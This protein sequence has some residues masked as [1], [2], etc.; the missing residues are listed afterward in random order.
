[1]PDAPRVTKTMEIK[2]L[3]ERAR[4]AF[5]ILPLLATGYDLFSAAKKALSYSDE[6]E[7][8]KILEAYRDVFRSHDTASAAVKIGAFTNLIYESPYSIHGGTLT[9]MAG[10]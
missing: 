7:L 9:V 10:R 5:K 1:M 2:K 4:Q 3:S 6:K 8:V